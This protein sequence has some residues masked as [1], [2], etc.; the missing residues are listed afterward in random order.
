MLIVRFLRY[1]LFALLVN[2]AASAAAGDPLK[3]LALGDSLTAGLGLEKGDS[4]P[5]RLETVLRAEGFDVRVINAGV[6]GDTTAGGVARLHWALA[7][8][9]D[10]VILELGANDGLRGLRPG[11]T[12]L[13]LDAMIRMLK[14]RD[15]PVL[16][17]GMRAPPNLGADYGD[18]FN[19]V[20]PRLAE[21]HG[22]AFYPFFLDGVATRPELNQADGI[23]PTPDGVDVIVSGILPFVKALI[24]DR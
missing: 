8:G 17:T 4:F 19:A 6:S 7:D 18:A 21:K 5:M 1:G 15:I 20:Y 11:S 13:N 9:A 2:A 14:D 22:V 10:A 12:E 16:L 24:A 3:I 23:H